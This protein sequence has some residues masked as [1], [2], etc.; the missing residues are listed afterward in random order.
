M[1][2]IVYMYICYMFLGRDPQCS[3]DLQKRL[4]TTELQGAG[5]SL[6]LQ[7][8][9]VNL[10]VLSNFIEQR[11]I[12][13]GLLLVQV[14][15]HLQEEQLVAQMRMSWPQ[16][17]DWSATDT[18]SWPQASCVSRWLALPLWLSGKEPACQC[19]RLKFDPGVRKIPWRRKQQPTPVFLPEKYLAV[20][21]PR[22]CKRVGHNLVTKPQHVWLAGVLGSQV[23]R[24]SPRHLQ[25]RLQAVRAVASFQSASPPLL[26]HVAPTSRVQKSSQMG[27]FPVRL[28]SETQVN[29]SPQIRAF[30]P[31]RLWA[32]SGKTF[33]D[34]QIHPNPQR[35]QARLPSRQKKE[36]KKVL[37]AWVVSN[38]FWSHRPQPARL[39]R[40]WDF[41]GKN[42]GVGCHS[43][44]RGIF[45]TQGWKPGLSHCGQT[46][47][48]LSHRAQIIW[49]LTLELQH[50]P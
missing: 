13:Q 48:H 22:C 43:F 11:F 36:R 37:V 39:L 14:Q 4:S 44:S 38:S 30:H 47:H 6:R 15:G 45:P 41:P 21:S 2:R 46:L 10:Q 19:R 18:Q 7:N 32:S 1:Y 33:R 40:P 24:P 26:T 12:Q 27:L 35:M 50:Q 16:N 25:L 9:V 3:A 34:L 5:I 8:T 17:K 20:Y 23:G 28:F 31:A 49:T 29:V 42:N